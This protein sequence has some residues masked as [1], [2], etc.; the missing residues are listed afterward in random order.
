M[1]D[2]GAR[3]EISYLWWAVVSLLVLSAIFIMAVDYRFEKIERKLN[4]R[5]SDSDSKERSTDPQA[6]HRAR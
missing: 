6:D 5:S 4:E 2:A 3:S 1:E